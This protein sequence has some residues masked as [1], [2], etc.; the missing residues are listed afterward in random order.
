MDT[1]QQQLSMLHAKGMTGKLCILENEQVRG[2]VLGAGPA[3][4][5]RFSWHMRVPAEYVIR[6]NE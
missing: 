3:G 6:Q 2:L 4:L 1:Q 5:G